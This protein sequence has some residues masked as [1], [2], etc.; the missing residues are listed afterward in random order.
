MRI[1]EL[2]R[3][4][5]SDLEH[6]IFRDYMDENVSLKHYQITRR[7]FELLVPTSDVRWFHY[8]EI[9]NMLDVPI[10]TIHRN[11]TGVELLKTE[12]YDKRK[13]TRLIQT[14]KSRISIIL[15]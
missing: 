1:L 15:L 8:E 12:L 11:Y 9:S 10:G 4:E 14:T 2:K 6:L 13:N 7:A 3:T 5:L